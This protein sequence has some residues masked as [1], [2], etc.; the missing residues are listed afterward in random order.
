M[1][2][3]LALALILLLGLAACGGN[4]ELAKAAKE[5]EEITGQKTTPQDVQEAIDQMSALSDKKVTA[6]DIVDLAR[7]AD[8]LANGL[9][10]ETPSEEWPLPDIPAWG[11]ADGLFWSEE[12]GEYTISVQGGDAERTQWAAELEKAGFKGF[13]EQPDLHYYKD[14]YEVELDENYGG[15]YR[16]TISK[17]RVQTGLPEE[18]ASLFPEYNGDGVLTFNGKDEQDGVQYYTFSA[19]GETREGAARYVQALIDAGFTEDDEGGYY[20]P[21]TGYYYKPAG[22]KKLGYQVEEYWYSWNEDAGKGWG[23]VYLSIAKE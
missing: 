10:M 5:I 19:M 14:G 3:L 6:Q 8:A 20:E 13:D 17:D 16:I 2:R 12:E 22:G 18:I 11:T 7:G 4:A 15:S 21:P 1:K 23:D 9:D